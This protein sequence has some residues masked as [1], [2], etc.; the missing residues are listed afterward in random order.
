MLLQM[1]SMHKRFPGVHALDDVNFDLAS[2]EIH[3]LA[4]ENGAGKS[5]LMNVL[6]GMY[7]PDSGRIFLDDVE[8]VIPSPSFAIRNSIGMV[9]QELNVVPDISIAENIFMGL[10][11]LSH[12]FMIDWKQTYEQAER[13][14]R[15][16]GTSVDVRKR[17]GDCNVAQLQLVQIARALVFGAKI[18]IL[19]EPTASLTFQEA[20]E[21]FE[22][23]FKLKDQGAGIIFISHHMDEVA[24][25][26]DRVTVMRDGRVVDTSPMKKNTVKQ[27]ITHMANREVLFSRFDRNFHS[28]TIVLQAENLCH[29]KKYEN[30]S[31]EVKQ[32]EIFGIGGL[33]GAGRTEVM[34][35]LFGEEPAEKGSI[36]LRGKKVTIKSPLQAINLG[37]GYLPEERRQQGI[38]PN[39]SVREN[40]TMPILP[41]ISRRGKIDRNKQTQVTHRSVRRMNV[42]T[43][44]IEKEIRDLSG[45]NQQKVLIGRLVEADLDIL[46]LD[47]PTKGIDVNA[48][49]EIHKLIHE[50]ADSGKT[51]IVVSSELEELINISDRIMVMNEGVV[52]GFIDPK[53]AIQKD[54]LNMAL[55]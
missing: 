8:T 19:D 16:L 43:P 12:G 22:I 31:F 29:R 46:I 3:S 7:Q 1:R 44:S 28:D 5:T 55:S 20:D 25:I 37:I 13:K 9:P 30:V 4:G 52:K 27:I 53:N 15:E 6:M 40:L 49:E 41:R 48:K 32:G 26:S 2:G 54:I 34:L 35:A 24:K 11:N 36:T 50:L 18:L 14:M 33:V 23:V 21:L 51:I 45:G 42:R 10:P 47:E 38:F 39:L 17:A